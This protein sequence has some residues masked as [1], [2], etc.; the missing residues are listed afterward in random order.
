MT[1]S[2]ALGNNVKRQGCSFVEQHRYVRRFT[3]TLSS[4]REWQATFQKLL[5]ASNSS[6]TLQSAT[7]CDVTAVVM[8][9]PHPYMMHT[10]VCV[11]ADL[12]NWMFD[13]CD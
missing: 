12:L 7:D 2:D 11:V 5:F 1:L 4:S 3:S 6:P 9:F 10:C 13:L 8:I